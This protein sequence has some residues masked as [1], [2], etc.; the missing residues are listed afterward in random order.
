MKATHSQELINR[1]KEYYINNDV[2][3]A[4]L[5]SNS[6][7]LFGTYFDIEL[8]KYY[9]KH[10]KNGSWSILKSNSGRK[11]ED[12]PMQ[13][14]LQ[15]VANKLYEMIIDDDSEVSSTQLAQ[16]AKTWSDLVDKAKLMK[17]TTSAKTSAQSVKD[18]FEK[19]QSK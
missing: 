7:T 19:M 14:K 11:T 18:I 2:S 16:L 15:K 6:Q 4:E 8:L 1:I 3:L 17:D 13:E 5:S 12:V 9:S 10:D